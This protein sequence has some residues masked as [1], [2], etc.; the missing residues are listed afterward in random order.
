M[1]SKIFF[2]VII[3]LEI[4]FLAAYNLSDV[5]E[6]ER[7]MQ[8]ASYGSKCHP[9]SLQACCAPNNICKK[10]GWGAHIT[11]YFCRYSGNLT[12]PCQRN[13]DCSDIN[14]A[15]CSVNKICECKN[16]YIDV[17]GQIC[18]PLLGGF[19]NI[20]ADC[21]PTNSECID[22]KCTCQLAFIS[23][24]IY[25]CI[26][27]PLGLSCENTRDCYP[28]G[29]IICSSDKVCSCRENHVIRNDAICAP[30][31]EEYCWND[32]SC[33]PNHSICVNNTC[34]CEPN[35]SSLLKYMCTLN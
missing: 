31:L 2:K 21:V 35:Y 11:T 12:D 9:H 18:A 5:Y 13:V 14:N 33:A 17:A 30:L 15:E 10:Q 1:N 27:T 7:R 24:S 32:E 28:R 19:C 22:N 23:Q 25:R 3:V 34:I 4:N 29:H 8:C 16:N 26:P 20:D 6:Y